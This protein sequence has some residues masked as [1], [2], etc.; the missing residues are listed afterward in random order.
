MIVA[1]PA[2]L[3]TWG[4]F[5]APVEM[6]LWSWYAVKLAKN[7]AWFLVSGGFSFAVALLLPLAPRSPRRETF[8]L[9]RDGRIRLAIEED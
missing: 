7:W 6:G 4:A 9:D 1:G 5:T 3:G 8:A 2:A